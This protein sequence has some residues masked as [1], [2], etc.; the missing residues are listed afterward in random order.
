MG[1]DCW[2]SCQARHLSSVTCFGRIVCY[3][4]ACAG[5]LSCSQQV[6][7]SQC[8]FP[9]RAPVS[10]FL[11]Q[12]P[13]SLPFIHARGTTWSTC[14][15]DEP[16][17]T[18]RAVNSPFTSCDIRA[19]FGTG[20]QPNSLNSLHSGRRQ[21]HACYCMSSVLIK[22][23]QLPVPAG[24]VTTTNEQS[25]TSAQKHSSNTPLHPAKLC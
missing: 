2:R 13:A 19:A 22:L 21:L 10:T 23:S 11:Q 1:L 24:T 17:D 16:V 5:A 12:T 20:Q 6:E 8:L 15:I 18:G 7:A 25:K 4:L 3:S 9:T 14:F